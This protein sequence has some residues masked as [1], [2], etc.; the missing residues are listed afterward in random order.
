MNTVPQNTQNSAPQNMPP[1]REDLLDAVEQIAVSALHVG[2]L[3]ARHGLNIG[4]EALKTSARS[5]DQVAEILGSVARQ[6]EE[7]ANAAQAAPAATVPVDVKP[8]DVVETKVEARVETKVE[9]PAPKKSEKK[10]VT[11]TA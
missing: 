5:L 10:N 6:F 9:T 1:V 11:P 2:K 8:V 3:W 7:N 4:Q